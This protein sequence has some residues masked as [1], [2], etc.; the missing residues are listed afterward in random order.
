MRY[1]ATVLF[2][3][4]FGNWA[5]VLDPSML[6]IYWPYVTKKYEVGNCCLP[7]HDQLPYPVLRMLLGLLLKNLLLCL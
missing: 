1:Y 7:H 3:S 4:S 5:K 6:A 2:A